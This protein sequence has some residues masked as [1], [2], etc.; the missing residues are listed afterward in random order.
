MQRYFDKLKEAV[1]VAV[2]LVALSAVIGWHWIA[3]S[4]EADAYNRVTGA[5]VS[6]WDALFLE[7]RVDGQAGK[8]GGVD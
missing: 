1:M 8:K 5:N 7:L 2:A 4:M 6:T 3:A